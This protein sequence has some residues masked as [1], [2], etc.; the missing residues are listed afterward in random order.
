MDE[1]SELRFFFSSGADVLSVNGFRSS[2]EVVG[3]VPGWVVGDDDE[4][5]EEPA[6]GREVMDN[7]RTMSGST[8]DRSCP[9]FDFI[10]V[11]IILRLALGITPGL[12][13]LKCKIP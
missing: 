5:E 10:P 2:V 12:L 11:V 1:A 13:W 3:T 6:R 4:E 8:Y 7:E 9:F